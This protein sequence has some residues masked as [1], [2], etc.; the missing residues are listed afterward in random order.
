MFKSV[1]SFAAALALTALSVNASPSPAPTARAAKAAT[2]ATANASAAVKP[3][4]ET[5]LG[6]ISSLDVHGQTLV[7]KEKSGSATFSVPAS[8]KITAHGKTIEIG[9]LKVG[10]KVEVT[11]S[12]EGSSMIAT[13]V[14][15][16]GHA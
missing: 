2:P 13:R 3:K 5:A 15:L 16:L 8:A 14:A 6:Q 12:R 10:E 7:L 11:Y 4:I 9:G 1:T